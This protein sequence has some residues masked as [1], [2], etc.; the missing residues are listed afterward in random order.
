[1]IGVFH[2][3]NQMD[4]TYPFFRHKRRLSGHWRA[5]ENAYQG[6]VLFY[7]MCRI[8]GSRIRLSYFLRRFF[9]TLQRDSKSQWMDPQDQTMY[10]ADSMAQ[11]CRPRLPDLLV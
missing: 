1:M 8:C 4:L 11:V 5:C 2:L 10:V 9:L 7:M 6:L 3:V